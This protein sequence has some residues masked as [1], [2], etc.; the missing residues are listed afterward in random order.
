MADRSLKKT[1]HQVWLAG[2]GA[3]ATAEQEGSD[4]F[5]TLV[6]RGQN[7]ESEVIKSRVLREI[8]QDLPS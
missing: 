7:L 3:L 1:P 6:K 5:Q 4:L 8:G 2:L